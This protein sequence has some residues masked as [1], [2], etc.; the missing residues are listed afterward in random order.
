VD[1]TSSSTTLLFEQWI[2]VEQ[3]LAYVFRQRCM[4]QYKRA[5]NVTPGRVVNFWKIK[6]LSGLGLLLV[7]VLILWGPLVL[8]VLIQILSPPIPNPI[9]AAN[10]QVSMNINVQNSV[11]SYSLF[12]I[13]ARQFVSIGCSSSEAAQYP[14]ISI[15]CNRSSSLVQSKIQVQRISFNSY[16]ESIWTAT[17]EIREFI[18]NE[19]KMPNVR[20]SFRCSELLCLF[21]AFSELYRSSSWGLDRQNSQRFFPLEYR[22]SVMYNQ[23]SA[24]LSGDQLNNLSIVFDNTNVTSTVSLSNLM[25]TSAFSLSFI[26]LHRL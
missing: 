21:S 20:V 6:L 19:L 16:S 8:S 12:S 15:A 18:S 1:W 5:Y 10:V 3:I 4:Q 23:T 26:I 13:A 17:P 14:A 9:T 24:S 25:P 7:V 22:Q 2:N 11:V